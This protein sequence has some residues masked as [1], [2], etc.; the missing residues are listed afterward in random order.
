MPLAAIPVALARSSTGLG[1]VR[2]RI[3]RAYSMML[4]NATYMIAIDGR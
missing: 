3:Q 2:S 4:T 1:G